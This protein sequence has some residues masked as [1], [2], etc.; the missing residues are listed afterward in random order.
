MVKIAIYVDTSGSMNERIH[1]ELDEGF[2]GESR[3]ILG[4]IFRG[5]GMKGRVRKHLVARAMWQNLVPTF[6]DRQTKI[7]TINSRGRSQ[8]LAPLGFRTEEDLLRVKFPNSNGGT[9]LWKFLVEEAEELAKDSVDWLFFLISDGM[10]R[11]RP[12]RSMEYKDFNR[13]SKPSR[14]LALMSNFTLLDLVCQNPLSTFSVRS[15]AQVVVHSST[16]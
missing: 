15:A 16:L 12:L 13:V 10:D 4:K 1:G 9:Y 6:K 7:S 11:V 5:I 3:S 2:S 8:V 14:V